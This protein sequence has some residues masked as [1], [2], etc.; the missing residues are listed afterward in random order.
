MQGL[1]RKIARLIGMMISRPLDLIWTA[2][3]KSEGGRERYRRGRKLK[4]MAAMNGDEKFTD[5][6]RLGPMDHH[7]AK[8]GHGKKEEMT[9]NSP[10]WNTK[11]GD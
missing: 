8:R 9:T 5:G 11:V 10:R 2:R 7:R 3:I 6:A 4:A 1:F